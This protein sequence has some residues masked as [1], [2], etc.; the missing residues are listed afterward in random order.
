MADR[1]ET[2]PRRHPSM[3][4]KDMVETY[5][6]RWSLEVTFQETK[7]HLGLEGPQN[8]TELAVQRTA[9][10]ALCL[11]SLVIVWYLKTGK[12]L[13]TARPA[14][15]PWYRSKTQPA[16]SGMLATLRRAS[17]A[18]RLF[19]SHGNASTLRKRLE[20]LLACLDAAA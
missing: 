2:M 11:Y 4:A 12:E 10:L 14:V 6:L 17:W 20:S 3:S 8:R 9:P 13:R 18:E 19:A 1:A 16:F 5:C 7:G 15:T